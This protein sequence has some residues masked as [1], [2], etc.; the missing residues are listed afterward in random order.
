MFLW[1]VERNLGQ[2]F[3][4]WGPVGLKASPCKSFLAHVVLKFK[5]GPCISLCVAF[6]SLIVERIRASSSQN[7]AFLSILGG[8]IC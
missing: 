1:R 4:G 6:F 7:Q 5:Q 3:G 8:K 2:I